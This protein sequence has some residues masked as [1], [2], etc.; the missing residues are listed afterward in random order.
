VIGLDDNGLGDGL[1]HGW[2]GRLDHRWRLG[3]G[4]W[5]W[6]WGG[7]GL[8]RSVLDHQVAVGPRRGKARRLS[9]A[10]GNP[11]DEPRDSEPERHHTDDSRP[12]QVSKPGGHSDRHEEPS[13]GEKTKDRS[14]ARQANAFPKRG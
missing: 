2:R 13:Q 1:D 12:R 8:R 11:F 10:P 5:L 6:L 9:F 7:W 14:R 3:I 4:L